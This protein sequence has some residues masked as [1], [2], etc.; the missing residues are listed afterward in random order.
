MVRTAAVPRLAGILL[1]AGASSRMR[2]S[3]ALLPWTDGC[4]LIACQVRSLRR[5]GFSPVF[6]VLGHEADRVRPQVPLFE[7]VH[8]V[9]HAGYAAGRATSVVAGLRV[10]PPDVDGVTVLNVDSPRT[11][12]IL[13]E[14]RRAF[15]VSKAPLAVVTHRGMAGHPWLFSAELL[16][17]LLGIT[18][19][20]LGLREVEQR[21][22]GEELRVEVN[23]S[24]A[25]ANINTETDYR[26]L[27]EEVPRNY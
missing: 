25:L 6:V 24:L 15:E 16:P 5:A 4:P 3:K 17:E 13:E 7:D 27:V 2:R 12:P 22:A 26:R 20:C 18:E 21:H 11:V 14:L 23:S 19:A 8:L 10:L 1:A 9:E